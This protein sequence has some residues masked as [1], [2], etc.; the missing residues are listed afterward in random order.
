ME[1][2]KVILFLSFPK[3]AF[4]GKIVKKNKVTHLTKDCVNKQ[5]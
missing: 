5:T 4:K 3:I 2:S 1:F